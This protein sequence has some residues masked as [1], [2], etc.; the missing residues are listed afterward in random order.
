MAGSLESSVQRLAGALDTLEAR[1]EA[2]AADLG[3]MTDA[4]DAARRQTQVAKSQAGAA[5]DDLADAIRDL[6]ALIAETEGR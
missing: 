3:A 4:V 1:I 6:K 5:A 2:R